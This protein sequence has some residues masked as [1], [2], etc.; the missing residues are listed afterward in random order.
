M[1]KQYLHA[2]SAVN[3]HTTLIFDLE[4]TDTQVITVGASTDIKVHS[5][6]EPGNPLVQVIEYAHSNGCHQVAIDAEGTRMIT[7]GFNGIMKVWSFNDGSWV[8][9]KD[10]TAALASARTWALD[11]SVD[12]QYLAGVN[13]EGRIQVWDLADNAT[14]I[15]DQE[16]KGVWGTCIDL[17][18]D[19]RFMA[20]GHTD[21]SVYIFSTE[22][23][24]MPFSLPGSVKQ[25]R[26][27]AFSPAGKLLAATGDSGVI[28][29][30]DTVSGEL[31]GSLTGNTAWVMNLSWSSTGEYLL[32]CSHDGK[33]KVYSMATKHCVATVSESDKVLWA[34]K[35][36]PKVGRAERFATVGDS[37]NI[38]IYREASA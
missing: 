12:G 19:G 32:S 34:A 18:Q 30:Y 23:G 3:A 6:T 31:V 35:W 10:L 26:V 13:P 1:S 22:T 24:R 15:R 17:S 36:L 9:D 8:A 11:L 25:V 29:L 21:G 16:T 14:Q 38:T 37:C 7:A 27:V 5:T 33:A 4:V 20:T 2:G 28:T